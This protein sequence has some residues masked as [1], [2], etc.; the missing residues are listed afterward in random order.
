MYTCNILLSDGDIHCHIL[1]KVF[2]RDEEHLSGFPNPT[3]G[4]LVP[5]LVG[6]HFN[7]NY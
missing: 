2:L 1:K 3:K 4:P 5:A 7:Q 6:G